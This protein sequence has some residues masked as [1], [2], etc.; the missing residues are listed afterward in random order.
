MRKNKNGFYI[1]K[2]GER[3]KKRK[4]VVYQPFCN[5]IVD[6]KQNYSKTYGNYMELVKGDCTI[7][8]KYIGGSE[9]ITD[10]KIIK[11]INQGFTIVD[12][13]Q[14]QNFVYEEAVAR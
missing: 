7:I 6:L 11:L 13:W 3:K 14:A 9:A 4:E 12:T 5:T 10:K 1:E 8:S 2:K